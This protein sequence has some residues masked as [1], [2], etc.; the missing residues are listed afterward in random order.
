MHR[1]RYS[2]SLIRVSAIDEAVGQNAVYIEL[3]K[4]SH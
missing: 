2:H 3:P 4:D 1:F